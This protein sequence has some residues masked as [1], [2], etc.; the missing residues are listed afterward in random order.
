MSGSFKHLVRQKDAKDVAS[1]CGGT[2]ASRESAV[3]TFRETSFEHFT[4]LMAT[5]CP[6]QSKNIDL[7]GYSI[8]PHARVLEHYRSCIFRHDCFRTVYYA[9]TAQVAE[10]AILEELP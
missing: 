3:I 6:E 7:Y 2:E 10:K 4:S 9:E 5:F 1:L 8:S